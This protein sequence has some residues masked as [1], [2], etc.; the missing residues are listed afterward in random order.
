[1]ADADAI[2]V[3]A[4]LAG[5]VAATELTAAGRRVVVVEQES[6]TNLGGQAFWSFGGLFFVD[7]PEQRRMGVKDSVEL[8]WQDWLGTAGFDRPEDHWPGLWARAY[9]DFAAGE[10]RAWLHEQGMRWFPV[11]GWAER[12]DGHAGG[13][14]NSVPRF[15][16]TWGT[17][18]G[19]VEPF[20]RKAIQAERDGLLTFAF[21]HRVDDLVVDGGAVTGVRGAVLATATES[22]GHPHQPRRRR[23]LRPCTAPAVIVTSGG[24]GGNHDLVRAAW[25]DRLGTP[26]DH[27]I[28]RRPRLRRRA[29]DRDRRGGRRLGDQPRPDV[30]LRRGHPQLG[31]DLARSRHPD[32]ARTVVDVVRRQRP[33][34][35]R[36]VLPGLRHPRDAG[37]PASDRPR[38]L[39]VRPDPEGHR[40]GVRPL[41]LGAEPRP[42]RQVGA[43]GARP[44]PPRGPE[45]GSGL[46]GPRRGLRDGRRRSRGWWS[47]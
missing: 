24:I 37:P 27:L 20:V 43:P 12:G 33:S 28:D 11:V 34:S 1:M 9:V 47:G 46:R 4:G 18:P 13:H 6:R 17:G 25:P 44:R 10:K 8:A 42:H 2:V 29:D 41:R 30:A 35:P 39:V 32:P 22:R 16:V 19:V 21:R 26:P 23:R 5:L 31:P 3:G 15:H 40:E 7:S 45:T 38:P 36:A 14:G